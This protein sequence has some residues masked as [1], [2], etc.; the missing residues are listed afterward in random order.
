M[1]GRFGLV[2][3]W[4]SEFGHCSGVLVLGIFRLVWGWYKYSFLWL[5]CLVSGMLLVGLP[6]LSCGVSWGLLVVVWLVMFDFL[7]L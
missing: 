4:V 2:S 3:G 7:V 5:G 1:G 6:V